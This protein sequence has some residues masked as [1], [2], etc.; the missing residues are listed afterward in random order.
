VLARHGRPPS[1]PHSVSLFSLRPLLEWTYLRRRS[2]G[3]TDG[4]TTSTMT[5]GLLSSTI[6]SRRSHITIS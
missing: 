6:S 4:S 1:W 3:T 2:T 5:S